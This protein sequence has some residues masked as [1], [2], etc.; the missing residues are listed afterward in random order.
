MARFSLFCPRCDTE[1]TPDY[2]GWSCPRCRSPLEVAVKYEFSEADVRRDV[3]SMWRY[4]CA[5]PFD[6]E[7]AVTLGEG[8]TPLVKR[9]LRGLDVFFKLEYLNPTGSF[10]DRGASVAVTRA[11]ILRVEPLHI[12]SSGNAGVAVS[13][14]GSA[15]NLKV[16]V[17]APRDA[18]KG[19]I[20]MMRLFGADVVL[21][22]T[23]GLA[24]DIA[25][26]AARSGGLY[27][28]HAWNPFFIEGTK[29]F[30][31]EVAEQLGWEP[32]DSVIVP[33]ATG[34][35]LLGA[36]KGFL[37][38]LASGVVERMPRL[39][40]VQAEGYTPVYD[41]LAPEPW[42]GGETKLADGL[43][44]SKP[45][46]LAEVV[47][48]IKSTGG[49]A[50]VVTDDEILTALR[51]LVKMG[52]LVEPTSATALAALRKLAESGALGGSVVV[53]LTGSGLKV[54]EEI[55]RLL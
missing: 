32:P 2:R 27:V 45:P 48:A 50:V 53:P 30:A 19:K 35:L 11:E 14:Y 13:A 55:E 4:A 33:T 6:L 10:K 37:E 31:F 47:E 1:L 22:D 44:V 40:A 34:S 42:R 8:C 15:A 21:A 54:C 52:F 38:M 51:E 18:P 17:Y 25:T 41:S 39:F 20:S 26:N 23:R 29:T 46:R 28:G 12:D 43:R 5:L 36:Y 9:R 16:R 24:T 7:E 3:Q 49:S